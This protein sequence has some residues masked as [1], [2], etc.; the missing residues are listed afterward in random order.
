MYLTIIYKNE[1]VAV[2]SQVLQIR[3]NE[4]VAIL[5]PGAELFHEYFHLL[6]EV[7]NLRFHLLI[8]VTNLRFH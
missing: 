4:L 2:L 3:A 7:T 1:R 8:E 6:L 5:S